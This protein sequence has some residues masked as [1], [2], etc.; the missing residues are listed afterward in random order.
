[1]RPKPQMT[2]SA[3]NRMSY[4]ARISLTFGQY[5]SGGMITPPA[6]WIGSAMKAATLSS[7]TSRIFFSSCSAAHTPNASGLMSPPSPN[8]YGCGMCTMPGIGRPPCSCM[9]LM[10]PRHAPAKVE[11][12]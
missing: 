10:P 9:P 5:V 11:P 2:S 7:P 12:W 6:P 8:Q 3:T 1:M 4:L